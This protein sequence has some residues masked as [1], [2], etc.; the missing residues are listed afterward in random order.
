V[1]EAVNQSFSLYCRF[2]DMSMLCLANTNNSRALSTWSGLS[3]ESEGSVG[4]L[5]GMARGK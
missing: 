1:I 4:Q 3:Y 5:P 2:K